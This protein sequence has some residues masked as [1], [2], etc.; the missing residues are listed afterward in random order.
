ML[1][2]PIFARISPVLG[3]VLLVCYLLY[4][5]LLFTDALRQTKNLEVAALSVI[6]SVYQLSA[7]GIGFFQE[8]VRRL[9]EDKNVK[10]TGSNIEYP[11]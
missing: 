3:K 11:S 5:L 7:Y 10:Y 2:V 4:L 9:R 6:A 8:G 1:S